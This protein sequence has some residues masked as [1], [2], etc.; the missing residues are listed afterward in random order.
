MIHYLQYIKTPLACNYTSIYMLIKGWYIMHTKIVFSIFSFLFY[1][2]FEGNAIESKSNWITTYMT[3]T[4]SF[5]LLGR[6]ALD[7]IQPHTEKKKQS[8]IHILLIPPIVEYINISITNLWY[9]TLMQ[10]FTQSL[11]GESNLLIL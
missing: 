11:L 8:Q 6:Y 7:L 10:F 2:Y 5:V 3:W 4:S 1:F 9:N